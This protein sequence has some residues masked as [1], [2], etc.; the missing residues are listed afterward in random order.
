MA[1]CGVP[2]KRLDGSVA[3]KRCVLGFGVDLGVAV[4]GG[5][6]GV[7]E[8]AADDVDLDA[9][10]EEVDGGGVPEG[11]RADPAAGSGSSRSAA[12]RRTIL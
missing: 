8:P 9:G 6:V 3:Q 2:P 10:F 4:G 5:Q 11:V 12:W 7:S 1:W